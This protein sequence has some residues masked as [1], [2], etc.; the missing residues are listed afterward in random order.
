MYDRSYHAWTELFRL[1]CRRLS[2]EKSVPFL[3][4]DNPDQRDCE[5]Q[6]ETEVKQPEPEKWHSKFATI[7]RPAQMPLE[8]RAGV[9]LIGGKPNENH[10]WEN[11][12]GNEFEERRSGRRPGQKQN[13]KDNAQGDKGMDMKQ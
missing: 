7:L 4:C 11:G 3:P 13:Q 5:R 2:A 8:D 6:K 12:G 1:P 10:G 9:H